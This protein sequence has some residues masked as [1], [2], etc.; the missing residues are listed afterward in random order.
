[1][2]E[3]LHLQAHLKHLEEAT[4]TQSVLLLV[5]SQITLSICLIVVHGGLFVIPCICVVL[6]NMFV[7]V[8]NFIISKA[9]LTCALFSLLPIEFF[10]ILSVPCHAIFFIYVVFLFIFLKLWFEC[11]TCFELYKETVLKWLCSN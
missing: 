6:K 8:K 1:M 9:L 4:M 7:F 11:W 3:T 5:V 10:R 2:M